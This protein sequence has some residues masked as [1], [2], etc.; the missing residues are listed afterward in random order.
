MLNEFLTYYK[1]D[2]IIPPADNNE[3]S[4]NNNQNNYE[5]EDGS[6]NAPDQIEVIIE[7][8]DPTEAPET[9]AAAPAETYAATVAVDPT[10]SSADGGMPA[11]LIQT[12]TI[13]IP[14][15]LA[16]LIAL[17]VVLI[18]SLKKKKKAQQPNPPYNG[19]NPPFN[20]NNG[21]PN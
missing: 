3:N 10:T 13:V 17:I 9:E 2:A 19:G 5:A 15:I 6:N 1:A 8:P 16:A 7:E 18:V 12:L 4:N 20:G 21:S 14:V 11:S